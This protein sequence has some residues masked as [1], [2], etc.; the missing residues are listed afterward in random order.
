M[1]KIAWLTSEFIPC[2]PY[3]IPCSA[4]LTDGYNQGH[5]IRAVFVNEYIYELYVGNVSGWLI[6]QVTK[7]R[8]LSWIGRVVSTVVPSLRAKTFGVSVRFRTHASIPSNK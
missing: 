1:T 2:G 7:S 4:G 8:V 6:F 5:G 3:Q